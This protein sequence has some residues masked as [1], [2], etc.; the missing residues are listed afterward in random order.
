[1]N[2]FKSKL[3]II[4]VSIL[5]IILQF[6]NLF[7]GNILVFEATNDGA[8]FDFKRLLQNKLFWWFLIGYIIFWI[9]IHILKSVDEKGDLCVEDA[10]AKNEIKLYNVVT[11][12][13]TRKNFEDADKTLKIID[14]MKKRR[15][16]K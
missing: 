7:I 10:I 3:N 11:K 6:A 16:E 5:E 15:T 9:I 14:E 8:T 13:T 1:M 2:W 4:V 12:Q